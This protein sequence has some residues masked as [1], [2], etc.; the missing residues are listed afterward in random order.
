MR[1]RGL[2][3]GQKKSADVVVRAEDAAHR[4]S[5]RKVGSVILVQGNPEIKKVPGVDEWF[6]A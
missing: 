3:V 1:G 4:E 2:T 6:T 5:Q